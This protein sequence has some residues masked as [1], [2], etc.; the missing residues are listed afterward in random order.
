MDRI[1]R[2]ETVNGVPGVGDLTNSWIIQYRGKIYFGYAGSTNTYPE[3]VLVLSLETKK[4]TYYNFDMEI[5]AVCIDF[6]ND[7]LICADENGY[8]WHIEDKTKTQDETTDISWEIESK[9]FT[10]STRAH[11]PRWIKYDIDASSATSVIG[12]IVLDGSIHQSHAVTGN[13]LTKRRLISVGNGQKCSMRVTGSGPVS[14]YT[15]ES[16]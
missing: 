6:T 5:P 16:E 2:G 11:F 12:S 9:D 7:R 3:N 13:R 15:M 8:T 14:I 1:F 10:L 4:I